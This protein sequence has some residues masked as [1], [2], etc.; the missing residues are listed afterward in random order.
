MNPRIADLDSNLTINLVT[1]VSKAYFI[2]IVP[3]T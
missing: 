1:S 3:R 2:K